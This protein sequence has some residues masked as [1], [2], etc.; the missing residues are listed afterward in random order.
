MTCKIIRILNRHGKLLKKIYG[1]DHLFFNR[2]DSIIK[3]IPEELRQFGI[4]K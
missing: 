3:E 4:F 1:D 2:A